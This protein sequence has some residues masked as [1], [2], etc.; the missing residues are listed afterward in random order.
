MSLLQKFTLSLGLLGFCSCSSISTGLGK[1]R[2]RAEARRDIQEGRL[3]LEIMGPPPPPWQETYQRLAKERYGIEQ[4]WVAGCMPS[5][6]VMGHADGY[7]EVMEAEIERRFGKDVLKKTAE[8][9]QKETP[10]PS[11]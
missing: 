6:R 4:R 11:F 8:E 1:V 7:D 10:Q 3:A 5:N 9:A 2:G